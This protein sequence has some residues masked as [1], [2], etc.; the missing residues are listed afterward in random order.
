MAHLNFVM[1]HP[2]ADGNGR[3]ARCLQTM[4]LSRQGIVEPMF[5]SVE[6]FLGKNTRSYYDVLAQVGRG[7][8]NP[9]NDARPWIEYM[10]NAHYQ[11]A[12]KLV[13][14]M[15]S[16]ERLWNEVEELVAQLKL[17]DRMVGPLVDAARG[18]RIRNVLYRKS[19]DVS[20]NLATR[21]F[22]ALLDSNLIEPRGEKR[23]RFYVASTTLTELRRKCYEPFRE[24]DPFAPENRAQYLP[25]VEP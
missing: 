25:G 16:M 1:I 6:E 17:H 23:G 24:G 2:F 15:N 14:R 11:Q 20:E 22:K 8:W 3:M 21:D 18:F 4:V 7:S 10:L 19:A 12:A 5:C 9:Q 13:W